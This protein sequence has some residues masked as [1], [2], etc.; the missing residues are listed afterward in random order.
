[1]FN[2]FKK[3]INNTINTD[4]EETRERLE[5][6]IT[7]ELLQ[8]VDNIS[9]Y[10]ESFKDFPFHTLKNSSLKMT[11]LQKR[12]VEKILEIVKPLNDLRYQICPSYMDDEKFWKIYFTHIKSVTKGIFEPTPTNTPTVAKSNDLLDELDSQ[13]DKLL[14]TQK[15]M[16]IDEGISEDEDSYFSENKYKLPYGNNSSK[17]STN[18]NNNN[19]TENNI[20]TD[21]TTNNINTPIKSPNSTPST[22]I[23]NNE[24]INNK[25]DILID[26][27]FENDSSLQD[28]DI[29][30]SNNSNSNSNNS[31][32]NNTNS[33]FD[34][35]NSLSPS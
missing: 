18:N 35:L 10:P 28:S 15:K 13:F 16:I 34:D 12:H 5:L 9:K 17:D 33:F 31:N 4:E 29:N 19:N 23:D 22:Q 6:G 2:A 27:N 1:M 11:K 24:N 3:L 25:D 8:L 7:P 26:T 30:N 21:N 14:A 20:N 32:N